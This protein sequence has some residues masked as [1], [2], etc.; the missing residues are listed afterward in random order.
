MRGLNMLPRGARVLYES[1]RLYRVPSNHTIMRVALLQEANGSVPQENHDGHDSTVRQLLSNCIAGMGV[2]YTEVGDASGVSIPTCHSSLQN[3][4]KGLAQSH[5]N[6]SLYSSTSGVPVP[7]WPLL[8]H[9]LSEL[10]VVWAT[11]EDSAVNLERC[12]A[13]VV[14]HSVSHRHD[15]VKALHHTLS[16]LPPS[17]PVVLAAQ[18]PLAT[19]MQGT[20]GMKSVYGEWR[21]VHTALAAQ[22]PAVYA[23][24][25]VCPEVW[26]QGFHLLY[27]AQSSALYRKPVLASNLPAI[28]DAIFAACDVACDGVWCR[29]DIDTLWYQVY[30]R[31]CSEEE[32][33]ALQGTKRG[34]DAGVDG[35]MTKLDVLEWMSAM[36]DS[37]RSDCCWAI[38]RAFGFDGQLSRNRSLS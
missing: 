11:N 33:S 8:S 22:H 2:S 10:D 4:A 25:Y 27:K 13:A 30:H 1:S 38:V 32:F 26:G 37:G 14:L 17:L 35:R 15:T 3:L 28:V 5:V 19:L 29:R 9:E 18:V 34:G 16:L 31:S 6:S 21:E 7:V 24:D 23:L 36:L 20:Y 12:N